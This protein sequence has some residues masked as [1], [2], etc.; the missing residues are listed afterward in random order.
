MRVAA[1]AVSVIVGMT[2]LGPSPFGTGLFTPGSGG[3][4]FAAAEMSPGRIRVAD[5]TG[6]TPPPSALTLSRP[7][8]YKPYQSQPPARAPLGPAEVEATLKARGF[9][10]VSDVRQRG[11][12]FLA[13]ATGPRG[14]RVR[15]VVDAASGEISGMQVIG[16]GR[17]R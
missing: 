17:R 1:A 10:D 3:R 4:P 9:V 15:L 6:P 7:D 11:R 5:D 8:P 14:E 2:L 16:F 12:T 13:E